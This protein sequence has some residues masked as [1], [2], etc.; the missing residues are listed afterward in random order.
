[1]KIL[2]NLQKGDPKILVVSDEEVAF[3][4]KILMRPERGVEILTEDT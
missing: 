3:R 1:M 4:S 2:R